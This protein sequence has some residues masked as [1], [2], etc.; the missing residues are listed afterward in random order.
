MACAVTGDGCK[1][2]VEICSDDG[3][4]CV[5][6]AEH[7]GSSYDIN[8]S[9]LAACVF[10]LLVLLA[11]RL[12]RLLRRNHGRLPDHPKAQILVLVTIMAVILVPLVVDVLGGRGRFSHPLLDH[13]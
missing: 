1:F 2:L 4:R 7:W 6:L 13:T 9:V 3:L 5:K 11:F 12:W 8:Q 10:V